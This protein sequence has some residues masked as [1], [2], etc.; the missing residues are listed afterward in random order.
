MIVLGKGKDIAHV[1]RV[2]L[3][4]VPRVP[5][6]RLEQT[7]KM[8][9]ELNPAGC[10]VGEEVRVIGNDSLEKLQILSGPFGVSLHACG[11]TQ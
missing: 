2:P 11:C 1:G 4:F 8:Q 3:N 7:P 6:R 9:I 10:R 5:R